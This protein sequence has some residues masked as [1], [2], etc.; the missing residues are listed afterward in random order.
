MPSAKCHNPKPMPDASANASAQATCIVSTL[1]SWICWL[2]ILHYCS[3]PAPHILYYEISKRLHF[4]FCCQQAAT[5]DDND[6]HDE[7]DLGIWGFGATKNHVNCN[8]VGELHF[9]D[10][11]RIWPNENDNHFIVLLMLCWVTG[12]CNNNYCNTGSMLPT[13]VYQVINRAATHFY[14]FLFLF[15]YPYI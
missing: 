3:T 7:I 10:N 2:L 13:R 6:L 15:F 11:V 1:I 12:Y 5:R 4:P 14:I 9:F 8:M